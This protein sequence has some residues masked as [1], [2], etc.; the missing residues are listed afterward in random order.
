VQE[1]ITTFDGGC[2]VNDCVNEQGAIF[3][4]LP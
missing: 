1:Q 3:E 2:D 4:P